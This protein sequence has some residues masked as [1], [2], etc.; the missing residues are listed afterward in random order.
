MY[1]LK[2]LDLCKLELRSARRSANRSAARGAIEGWG[3]DACL[4]L[5]GCLLR[6]HDVPD[7][8][9]EY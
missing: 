9:P 1:L 3:R 8:V 2:E 4:G 6:P 7:E 5:T